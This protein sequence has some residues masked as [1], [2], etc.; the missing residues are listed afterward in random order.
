MH[1][2]TATPFT[3]GRRSKVRTAADELWE[4]DRDEEGG[5]TGEGR[6]FNGE[7]PL[8]TQVDEEVSSQSGVFRPVYAEDGFIVARSKPTRQVRG[9]GKRKRDR[10]RGGS[11]EDATTCICMNVHGMSCVHVRTTC[12]CI[13]QYTLYVH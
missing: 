2:K 8:G 5:A 7:N 13:C 11:E 1:S 4:E 9:G 12:T 6:G 3:I 10:E